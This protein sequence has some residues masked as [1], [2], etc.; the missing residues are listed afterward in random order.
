MTAAG[1]SNARLVKRLLLA[2]TAMFGFGFAMVPLYNVFCDLTG[3]NG[4]VGGRV[5]AVGVEADLNRTVMVE[6]VANLNQTMPWEFRPEVS[7]MEVHPGK[8][9]RTSFYA[10]NRTDRIMVGQA[11]PSVTPGTA[12]QHFKKTECFCFNNQPLEGG[13]VAEMPL[14]FIIDQDLPRDIKTITLSYTIFDI[15]DM[16]NGAVAAR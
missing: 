16:A 15:T 8:V 2:V 14:Q 6:F 9:Y 1:S 4:K 12:A 10:Q 3:L 13:G 5:E 11:I 7:R